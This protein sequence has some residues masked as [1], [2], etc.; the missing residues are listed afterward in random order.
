L[1]RVFY[2]QTNS[3][4]RRRS[5]RWRKTKKPRWRKLSFKSLLRT[6]QRFNNFKSKSMNSFKKR[7]NS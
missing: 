2:L 4:I 5:I 7:K 1:L 6:K 3:V